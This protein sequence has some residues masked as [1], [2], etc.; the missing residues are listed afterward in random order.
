MANANVVLW[1]WRLMLV[2]NCLQ[3]VYNLITHF[4]QVFPGS[5]QRLS[6]LIDRRLLVLLNKHVIL[7]LMTVSNKRHK[8]LQV[9]P[10]FPLPNDPLTIHA[11][12]IL[13]L[14]HQVPKCQ[15]LCHRVQPV[16]PQMHL[17]MRYVQVVLK[18]THHRLLIGIFHKQGLVV[19]FLQVCE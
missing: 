1:L 17:C 15:C 18:Y 19:A 9:R 2:Q 5:F 7:L 14:N 11:S 12:L 13:L 16:L 10:A 8:I 6:Y 4:R 3:I